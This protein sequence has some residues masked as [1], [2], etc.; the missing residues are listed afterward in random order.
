[1]AG[2]IQFEDID[3]IGPNDWAAVWFDSS[4]ISPRKLL[5][6]TFMGEKAVQGEVAYLAIDDNSFQIGE[7]NVRI[8]GEG[9]TVTITNDDFYKTQ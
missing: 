4:T 8:P 7:A 3:V 6:K 5:F 1:M 2:T 9:L